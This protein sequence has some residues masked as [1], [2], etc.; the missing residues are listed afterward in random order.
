MAYNVT[1]ANGDTLPRPCRSVCQHVESTCGWLVMRM[2]IRPAAP[3]GMFD[4][5]SYVDGTWPACA[6]AIDAAVWPTCLSTP[7]P[8]MVTPPLPPPPQPT[9]PSWHACTADGCGCGEHAAD[10]MRY[11]A[12]GRCRP[13][14]PG[15]SGIGSCTALDADRHLLFHL[16]LVAI[17]VAALLAGGVALAHAMLGCLHGARRALPSHGAAQTERRPPARLP[18]SGAARLRAC[19]VGAPAALAAWQGRQFGELGWRVA[20]R[21]WATLVITTLLAL[22]LTCGLSLMH[23]RRDALTMWLPVDS[24]AQVR[25]ACALELPAMH[26]HSSCLRCMR[27]RAACDACALELPARRSLCHASPPFCEQAAPVRASMRVRHA[28]TLIMRPI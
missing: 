8:P 23:I 24:E 17:G 20:L 27:T 22:T 21:P 9:R 14:P 28:H 1:C 12:C 7:P 3:S 10:T 6:S 25:L 4:C 15:A 5:D 18:S 11:D 16:C 13:V 26:A 2:G 19:A